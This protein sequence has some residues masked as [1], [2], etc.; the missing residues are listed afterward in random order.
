MTSKLF[1]QGLY[2]SDAKFLQKLSNAFIF[3]NG[4]DAE[5]LPRK[6]MNRDP[7]LNEPL[8]SVFETAIQIDVYV[9]NQEMFFPGNQTLNMNGFNFA[10]NAASLVI[11]RDAFIA[12]TKMVAPHEGDLIY[13]HANK[14]LFEIIDVNAKD[15]VTSGGR[16]FTFTCSIKPY[17]YGEGY[18][19]FSD[20]KESNSNSGSLIDDL[21]NAVDDSKWRDG[22]KDDEQSM[23][24]MEEHLGEQAQNAD[25]EC[26]VGGQIHR[27][28][29]TF[30][31]N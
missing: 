19:D 11:S 6:V 3:E 27:D 15:S 26:S 9:G 4:I 8:S 25:I 29:S 21:V 14:M 18:A 16:I 20:I 5:Y 12:K 31:F 30:G 7:V 17:T 13:L 1:N 2:N 23:V 24:D 10:F 22:C 28:K